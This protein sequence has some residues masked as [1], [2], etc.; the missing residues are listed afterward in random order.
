[1]YIV[2]QWEIQQEINYYEDLDVG[3][4][5]MVRWILGK[6]DGDMRTGSIRCKM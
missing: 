5:T 1:M 3:G 4:S 6:Q 2:V